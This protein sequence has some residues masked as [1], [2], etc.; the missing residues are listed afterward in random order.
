MPDLDNRPP[1][2]VLVHGEWAPVRIALVAQ[3]SLSS[4][5]SVIDGVALGPAADRILLAGQ[6]APAENGIYVLTAAGAINGYNY[7]EDAEDSPTGTAGKLHYVVCTGGAYVIGTSGRVIGPTS[8]ALNEE[9]AGAS[10]FIEPFE[11]GIFAAGALGAAGTVTIY[12]LTT[13]T[14]ATDADSA[15]EFRSGRRVSVASGTY[16][17]AWVLLDSIAVLG[18]SVVRFTQHSY[19][20]AT[21]S[22]SATDSTPG[23]AAHGVPPADNSTPVYIASGVRLPLTDGS[24]RPVEGAIGGQFS[25]VTH[26]I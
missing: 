22:E 25:S 23:V 12:S 17:G 24:G 9:G 19:A 11:G 20:A 1:E 8:T 6:T 4:P 26:T 5:A 10:G 7:E 16:R 14:R 21:P 18:T 2:V 13:L 15:G 3:T